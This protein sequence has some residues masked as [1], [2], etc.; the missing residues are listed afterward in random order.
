MHFPRDVIMRRQPVGQKRL[1]G[2]LVARV[3]SVNRLL[4]AKVEFGSLQRFDNAIGDG[5]EIPEERH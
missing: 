5:G 4:E 3:Q 1:Q 2:T